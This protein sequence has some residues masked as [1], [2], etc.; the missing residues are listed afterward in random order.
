M[1]AFL[2]FQQMLF[3]II[4]VCALP[5]RN[6]QLSSLEERGR[7]LMNYTSKKEIKTLS[8]TLAHSYTSTNTHTYTISIYVHMCTYSLL[9]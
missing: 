8:C 9:L 5:T 7:Q 1:Y 2:Y 4:F 3:F 6:R